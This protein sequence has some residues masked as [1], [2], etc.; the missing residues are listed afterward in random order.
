MLCKINGNIRIL[1]VDCNHFLPFTDLIMTRME[2]L[3]TFQVSAKLETFS[4][5]DT[6]YSK[7]RHN[8]KTAF[9]GKI[10]LI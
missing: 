8:F 10:L 1:L 5:L 2:T 9:P 4:R 7:N 6:I 3:K